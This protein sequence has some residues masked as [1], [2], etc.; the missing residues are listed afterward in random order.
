MVRTIRQTWS[1][2]N[3]SGRLSIILGVFVILGF[4]ALLLSP[5]LRS[6]LATSVLM[7]MI[8][9]III[10]MTAYSVSLLAISLMMKDYLWSFL[11]II[12][13]S[14]FFKTLRKI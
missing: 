5:G 6:G 13:F 10:P 9:V 1:E 4:I 7:G 14:L 8:Y 11:I 12:G 3:V 2:S